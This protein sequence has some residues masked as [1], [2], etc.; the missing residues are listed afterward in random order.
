[1]FGCTTSLGTDTLCLQSSTAY[2]FGTIAQGPAAAGDDDI[3][4]GEGVG[5]TE[6]DWGVP[7]ACEAEAS[8]DL[9]DE[10]EL[11]ESPPDCDYS[12]GDNETEVRSA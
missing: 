1:M 10:D 4:P 3:L 12:I 2:R 7:I 9:G 11:A 8:D 5:D 6:D